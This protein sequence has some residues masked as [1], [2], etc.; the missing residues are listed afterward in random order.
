M[1][2]TKLLR[3]KNR[4]R[5]E[6]PKNQNFCSVRYNSVRFSV[7]G[8]KVPTPATSRVGR[9][10][11][12]ITRTIGQGIHSPKYFTLGMPNLVCEKEG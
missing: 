4:N 3:Y 12:T 11:E 7:Y 1:P 8:K 6:L 5:I 10:E 2:K 9:I